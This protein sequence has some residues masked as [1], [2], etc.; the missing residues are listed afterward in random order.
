MIIQSESILTDPLVSVVIPS[1]NRRDTVSKTIDSI[2]DQIC[3]F[4]F[5]IIIGDDFSTDNVR[6]VLLDYQKKYPQKITLIFQEKNIGLGANWATCVKHCRG[7][8]IANCDNDDYWHNSEKIQIQVDFLDA[9]PQYG[10]LHTNYR[11]HNRETDE[12]KEV[13]VSNDVFDMPMQKVIFTGKFRCCNATIMY[14]KE[15]IDKYLPLDDYIKYQFTLQDWNTWIILAAYTEFYCLPVS[16][17]T[18]GIETESITRPK[19]YNQ[20]EVRLKKEKECYKYVCQ[21]FPNVLL[22]DEKGYDSYVNNTLL[23]LAF[24]KFDYKSARKYA[25][26]IFALG[27]RNIKVICSEYIL[28]FYLYAFLKKMKSSK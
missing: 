21:L 23:N 16:T 28:L 26:L 20:I 5:E 2:L 13:V 7:K 12:I 27:S 10:V 17:A 6:N 22:F 19:T 18:F 25:N 9:N 11:N 24:R 3:N 8:Y 4:E 1:Y 14:R 15:L